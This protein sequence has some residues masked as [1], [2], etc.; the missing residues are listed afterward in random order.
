MIPARHRE[1]S[2]S[3]MARRLTM[4]MVS[5]HIRP[6]GRQVRLLSSR[7]RIIISP[8]DDPATSGIYLDHTIQ[9][10]QLR[11]CNIRTDSPDRI[12]PCTSTKAINHPPYVSPRLTR[13]CKMPPHPPTPK[14]HTRPPAPSRRFVKEED[15]DKVRPNHR[16]KERH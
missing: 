4:R 1:L 7:K 12:V 14:P 10:R 9:N 3:E 6:V 13:T 2:S 8:P 11:T 16:P 15:P 5:K